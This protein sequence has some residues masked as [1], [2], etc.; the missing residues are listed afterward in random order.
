VTG[1][2][3][4][5]FRYPFRKYQR[6]IL[7]RVESGAS[8]EKH[9]IVAPPGSG[10]T[11]VGLELIRSFGEPAVVFAPTATIQR[12]W[13]EEVGMFT[14][15]PTDGIVGEDPEN[16]SWINVFT[17]A[18]ISTSKDSRALLRETAQNMW[19]EEI[20]QR[21]GIPTGA[22]ARERLD[23]IRRNNPDAYSK[24]LGRRAGRV[25]RDLL[26]REDA[27]V[28]RFLHPN[29]RGL[30]D[31]LVA[32]GVKTVVLDECHHLLDYWAIVLRYLIGRIEGVRVIGLTATLPSPEDGHEY[33][34][35]TG[36][37]GDVDFEVPTPAVVKEGDLAPYRDLVY[38]TEPTRRETVY[39]NDVQRVFEKEISSL[40]GDGEL[41]DWAARAALGQNLDG[42]P[43]EELLR[44]EPV[45]AVAMLR[46]LRRVGQ[47]IPGD[48]TLLPPEINEPLTLEDWAALLERYALDYL[49]PSPREEDHRELSRLRRM[50][51]P[52]GL[53]LTER[54][55]RASRSPGD[56]V[57]ALSESKDEAACRILAAE[58]AAMGEDLRAVVLTDFERASSGARP[59]EALDRE[60]GSARRVF[61][62][63]AHHRE[64]GRLDPIMVTGR[65]VLADA[66]LGEALI[67]RFNDRLASTGMRA[68]CRY[69]KTDIPGV[70]EVAGEGSDWSSRTYVSLVTAAFEEGVTRCLVGTRGILGEGW[71]SLTLN[72]LVDLTSVTTSTSVQQI[73]GRGLRKNPSWP[74]KVAHN[75]DVICVARDFERGDSDL[76]RFARRHGRYWGV[77]AYPPERG[78][79]VKSTY[80]VD[81]AL[82]FEL[83]VR[84]FRETSFDRYTR[85]SLV[86]VG[87]RDESHDLWRV[88]EDYSN[89]SYSATRLEVRDLKLRTAYTLQDS[90][91]SVMRSFRASVVAVFLLSLYEILVYAFSAGETPGWSILG[92][93]LV[94]AAVT[95]FLANLRSAYRLG[96][97]LLVEQRPDAILL[98]VGRA[99]ACALGDAGLAVR[100]FA[101]EN[102]RV[103]ERPDGS[104]EVSLNHATTED[105]DLFM[106]SYREIFAP[107]RD[108]RYLILRNEDRLPNVVFRPL[109]MALR[110]LFRNA[111]DY[112]NAL[113][114]VPG[115]LATRKDRAETLA[116]HWERYVGGG[117]LFY[118][119][120]EEGREALLRARA[121]RRPKPKDAA[122][123]VWR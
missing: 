20:S 77:V 16:L 98:D 73:R 6:M 17:Y 121:Q 93:A 43:L 60:A 110:P 76:R 117:R 29:A 53:T 66:G 88:G 21:E 44:A 90:L 11:I 30:M 63:L 97:A 26:R 87:R 74:R 72:T 102:V 78:R 31:R 65:V 113:H 103:T 52:F 116:R 59:E 45:F 85:R 120:N 2:D 42:A 23:T 4:L 114:P 51:L 75:W 108:Q 13:R 40:A 86:W 64:A 89:F 106:R 54:G 95:T 80:H 57:L 3:S 32:G 7:A 37:L 22:A 92:V 112:P 123:E 41:G 25:K 38:F 82:T 61:E 62:R 69:E 68:R 28:A 109:W 10:K 5:S 33:D 47:P 105:A 70:L 58:H 18:R 49:R 94:I 107:V 83:A 12:Q 81:P 115:V 104:Y 1:L 8:D 48:A 34:N 39:L 79:V 111:T 56:L 35:Y 27:D 19:L 101:P 24:E 119:R 67:T 122:F 71:D 118:T 55:L 36:L 50:L 9:H 46:F 99:L 15:G 84:G 100:G 14:D 96:K 91:A